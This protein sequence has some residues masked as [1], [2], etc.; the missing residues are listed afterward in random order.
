M[1]NNFENVEVKE[2][3]ATE[4]ESIKELFYAGEQRLVGIKDNVV[5]FSCHK[6][7]EI[8][9]INKEGETEGHKT[10]DW[11]SENIKKILSE[12]N[13]EDM[14]FSEKDWEEYENS[15][16]NKTNAELQEIIRNMLKKYN[17]NRN[18][19]FTTDKNIIA[20]SEEKEGIYKFL[21]VREDPFK[22]L[23]TGNP[24][25]SHVFHDPGTEE[26]KAGN[27]TFLYIPLFVFQ[28]FLMMLDNE[29]KKFEITTD[30]VPENVREY[31][32][33]SCIFE[34]DEKRYDYAVHGIGEYKI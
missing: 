21:T 1:D 31:L 32:L 11:I 34:G 17:K 16:K 29:E 3:Q 22:G 7:E 25:K 4:L 2:S 33:N 10:Y 28:R 30:E 6:C 23:V 26:T 20:E 8:G 27:S 9:T 13:F 19:Y 15:F 18:V 5:S 14:E 24:Y 12:N